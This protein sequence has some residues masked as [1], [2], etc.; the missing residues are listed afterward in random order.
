[1]LHTS[2]FLECSWQEDSQVVSVRAIL[3][4]TYPQ[5]EEAIHE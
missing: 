4:R 5:E 3:P 2:R 1:M